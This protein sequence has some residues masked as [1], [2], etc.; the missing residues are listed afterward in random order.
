MVRTPNT[1][2]IHLW[3]VGQDEVK[4]VQYTE[5]E[6]RLKDLTLTMNKFSIDVQSNKGD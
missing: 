6:G 2:F 3:I 4:F 5:A 1:S